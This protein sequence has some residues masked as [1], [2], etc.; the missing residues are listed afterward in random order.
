MR[1]MRRAAGVALGAAAWWLVSCRDLPAPEGGVLSVSPVR[2]PSPGVVVGDTMRDSTGVVAPLGVSAYGVS[3]DTLENVTPTFVVL[4]TGAHLAGALLIGD[5][6]GRSVRIVGTVE[7][8]Q[9]QPATVKVTL[10]PDTLV[11][12]DSVLQRRKYSLVSGDTI[13]AAELATTVFHR[14]GA[15]TSGVEA[16]IV[17]YAIERSPPSNGNGLTLLLMNGNVASDR[18][19]TDGGGR[20]SRT[21]RFR[22]L[23]KTTFTSDTASVTATA[24]YRGRAIGRVLFTLIFNSQ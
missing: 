15:I 18:D 22:L 17:R 13:V 1:R 24:S 14:V 23:A 5:Q 10:S 3:G 9:T 4:D 2:L 7:A 21:A 6:D 12:A 19:T 11:A 16:V 8:V 20:A